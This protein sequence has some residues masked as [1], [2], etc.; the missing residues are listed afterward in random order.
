MTRRYL[1]KSRFK[2]AAECPRKLFYAGKGAYRDASG[3]NALLKSLADGGFQV[4]ELAKHL[5]PGG[6]EIDAVG[7]AEALSQ[8]AERMRQ[9][10][11]TLFE[12]A[13]AYGDFLVRVDVLIKT[14]NSIKLVEVKSKSFRSDD[15]QIE[16]RDG[17]LKPGFRPYIEDIAFQTYVV[18]KAYPDCRVTSFLL[19]P[20]K[21]RTASV[22]RMNQL[23]KIEQKQGR[24]K[25][26]SDPKA[27]EL[28]FETSLLCELNVDRYIG[29]VH[30]Q[31]ISFPGGNGSMAEIAQIWAEAYREDRPL[32]P[33]IGAH[34]SSCQFKAAPGDS[35]KSGF[36]ECWSEATGLSDGELTEATVLDLW[37]FRGKQR[38][39]ESG[40]VKLSQVTLD[41]LG[42]AS[43]VHG[44]SNPE[45]QWLQVQW[46]A[47][48]ESL[49]MEY[50]S[51]GFFLDRDYMAI[52]M[53]S[54]RYPLHF[55]DFETSAVALP[56]HAGMRPYENVAFQFSHHVLEQDRA[57]RHAD[58]FLLAEVGVFPNYEFARALRNALAGDSGSVFMWATH[59]NTILTHIVDQLNGRG[60]APADAAELIA[61]LKTLIK[62]GDRAMIDLRTVAQKAYFHP[63]TKGSNSIKKVLP[64]VLGSSAFLRKRYSRPIYGAVDGIPSKNFCDMVWWTQDE[65]GLVEDPYKKLKTEDVTGQ[66][67]A[68][69]TDGDLDIIGGGEA[70][71]AYGRLQFEALNEDSRTALKDKL[72]RYCELD[73]LAM[74]MIVE[75]WKA[76]CGL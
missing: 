73:T 14:G 56:F 17:S 7:N 25:V 22:D 76:E 30:E 9:E 12:P 68:S 2:L 20:D 23:F 36:H 10:N 42:S 26:N 53:E 57:L 55:I 74:A 40:T 13:I 44:L 47:D 16:G 46:S 38:L 75:G 37:N 4:G 34:C 67:T 6:I 54:W 61:F 63:S 41:D 32:R 18:Q 60:D 50:K 58:Q 66:P 45:R 3:D 19:L 33:V 11:V 31:G 29:R 51:A 69:V 72:L 65:F 52:E 8:T 39:I 28:T 27:M 59:E 48:L 21:A 62:G 70:T 5:Y 49:P 24:T 64:A 15:P 1:T 43:S 35:L 71:M